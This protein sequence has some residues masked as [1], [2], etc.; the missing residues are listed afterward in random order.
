MI[1]MPI[2][3]HLVDKHPVLVVGDN[4]RADVL[5]PHLQ[6]LFIRHALRTKNAF[7]NDYMEI[8]HLAY[9]Y[10]YTFLP[11]LPP[12]CTLTGENFITLI[13][14]LVLKVAWRNYGNILCLRDAVVN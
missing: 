4:S 8:S 7:Y 9:I 11:I 5:P 13:F 14:C 6:H 10:T 1:G 2:S 3:T 12:T